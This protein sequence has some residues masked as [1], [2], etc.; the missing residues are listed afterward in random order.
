MAVVNLVYGISFPLL[1]LVLDAQGINKT[2]IG[3]STVSQALAVI[4]VAPLTPRVLHRYNPAR[5]M[6]WVALVVA[7][8]FFL[9]GVFPNVYF[10]FPLRFIIGGLTGLLWIASEALI[11]EMADEHVRGRV[12]GLYSSIGAAG[13]ALGP[14]LLIV[15]GSQGLLPF[16]AT[17]GFL[18]LAALPLFLVQRDHKL[19]SK[20]PSGGVWAA[21]VLAPAIMLA[22]LVYAA[23]AESVI[24]FFPLFGLHLGLSESASL[25]LLTVLG[26]GSMLLILPLSHLADRV[27]RMRMLLV[28]V[29]LTMVGLLLMPELIQKPVL[30]PIFMFVFGGIEG[31][32]YALGVTLVG[33]RFRSGGLAAATTAFTSCWAVGTIVGPPIV[34]AGMDHF[35]ADSMAL[36]IFFL[37]A[38]YLPIALFSSWRGAPGDT[39]PV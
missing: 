5:L 24:T 7:L 14:L 22:N 29:V 19:E 15:T 32:I 18:L 17:S 13:F 36:M 25:G 28:C 11:N 9:A 1:A 3:L 21:F 10:W 31:M 30:G 16:V 20:A 27:H 2:L 12:I 6:Q 37:F 23:S 26:F 38:A 8:L 35:G 39:G 4:F 33:E 34:G